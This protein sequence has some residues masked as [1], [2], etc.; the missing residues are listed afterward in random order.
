MRCCL[1]SLVL[2]SLCF[3]GRPA[4]RAE[5]RGP[6]T[7]FG[8]KGSVT[9]VPCSRRGAHTLDARAWSPA[10]TR[11]A[12]TR[13]ETF[14]FANPAN[15]RGRSQPPPA[16]DRDFAG[17]PSGEWGSHIWSLPPSDAPLVVP[18]SQSR[19]A[20]V[21]GLVRRAP[22][23][24]GGPQGACSTLDSLNS[25][26]IVCALSM[27]PKQCEASCPRRRHFAS[28]ISSCFLYFLRAPL[29][30]S[31]P[32]R[33]SCS[34]SLVAELPPPLLFFLRPLLLLLS[35]RLPPHR[36]SAR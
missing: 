30:P 2:C 5:A 27:L 22:T 21:L 28:I 4:S 23:S 8:E 25:C 24:Y 10:P 35:L 6:R 11:S 34:A 3:G 36:P 17:T 1:M 13:Q 26:H 29:L 33:V 14:R 7:R 12:P 19:W 31:W 9:Q 18:G 32:W 16:L 15:V 20:A